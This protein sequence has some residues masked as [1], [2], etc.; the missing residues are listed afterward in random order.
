[1]KLLSSLSHVFGGCARRAIDR[2]PGE[3]TDAQGAVMQGPLTVGTTPP[4]S[5][6]SAT[7]QSGK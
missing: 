3:R 6:A 1:M 5:S 2:N 4:A 7:D